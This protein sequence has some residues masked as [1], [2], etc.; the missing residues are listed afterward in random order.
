[1]KN[2]LRKN[3]MIRNTYVDIMFAVGLFSVVFVLLYAVTNYNAENTKIAFHGAKSFSSGWQITA[4][5]DEEQGYCTVYQNTLPKESYDDSVL[6]FLSTNE[7]VEVLIDSDSV[8]EYGYKTDAF[9]V[10]DSGSVYHL[11]ELPEG[12]ELKPIEIRF[13]H[14]NYVDESVENHSFLLDSQ[15]NITFQLLKNNFLSVMISII[16]ALCGILVIA[17]S[18]FSIRR[19]NNFRPQWYLGVFILFA[20]IWLTTDTLFFQFLFENKFISYFLSN[21]AFMFMPYSFLMFTREKFLKYRMPITILVVVSWA[22]FA[23]RVICYLW[24]SISFEKWL[25]LSHILILLAIILTAV[26]CFMERKS[27]EGQNLL[28]AMFIL[29]FFAILALISYYK[30][31][32]QHFN[33]VL[34]Y[35]RDFFYVGMIFFI[36]I[37]V[38][39]SY[40]EGVTARKKAMLSEFYKESAYTDVMTKVG[41]RMAFR[42]DFDEVNREMDKHSS[43]SVIMLDLNNLKQI[44]D[45]YGHSAGDA[46]LCNLSGCLKESFSNIGRIYRIGGDEF[47]VLIVDLDNDEVEKSI[48]SFWKQTE[49]YNNEQ[50]SS[51]HIAIGVAFRDKNENIDKNIHEL[52]Q[53][54]DGR[55]YEDKKRK[56]LKNIK[57]ACENAKKNNDEFN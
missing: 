49:K 37:L 4:S 19:S 8:F 30:N 38:Y 11:V 14:N 35:Y 15:G 16:I 25:F 40:K 7:K 33:P 3:A 1:M 5:A 6:C 57:E 54:A 42:E 32:Q 28:A 29:S 26:I 18:L 10:N 45:F 24:S 13:Y 31:N 22:Y 12:S 23:I 21:F 52:F 46:L 36:G 44:N 27:K 9:L 56:K 53:L 43:V 47:V 2:R 41:S 55:M 51:K 48:E 34:N 20:A 17:N 50:L 39:D